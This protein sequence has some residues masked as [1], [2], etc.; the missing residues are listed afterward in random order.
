MLTSKITNESIQI[1]SLISLGIRIMKYFVTSVKRLGS[2]ALGQISKIVEQPE[3]ARLTLAAVTVH[4][5]AR[6]ASLYLK[7]SE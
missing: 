7:C 4:R 5:K 2:R 1:D 3:P 6:L